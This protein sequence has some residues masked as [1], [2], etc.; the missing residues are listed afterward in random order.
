MK[1]EYVYVQ[2]KKDDYIEI[3]DGILTVKR[4]WRTVTDKV[5]NF[6]LS[7]IHIASPFGIHTLRFMLQHFDKG[8]RWAYDSTAK[9]E[10]IDAAHEWME[11]MDKYGVFEK[12]SWQ[13][14]HYNL[15]AREN[16]MVHPHIEKG[17]Q[18]CPN[19]GGVNYH[20]FVEEKVIRKGKTKTTVSLNLNPLKPFTV[21]DQKEKVVREPWTV[22]ESKFVCDDCGE[23]F[24]PDR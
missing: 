17:R 2:L 24:L 11:I 20:A 16:A 12:R 23:I 4:D 13:D 6:V 8:F 19:C 14:V 22:Q 9:K 5:E 15:N 21:F 10:E 18:K 7:H 1:Q 3:K